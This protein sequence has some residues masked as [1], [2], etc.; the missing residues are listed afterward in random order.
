MPRYFQAPRRCSC[1]GHRAGRP[2]EKSDAEDLQGYREW[3]SEILTRPSTGNGPNASLGAIYLEVRVLAQVSFLRADF[4]ADQSDMKG[5]AIASVIVG[6]HEGKA[7][8][9]RGVVRRHPIAE[10]LQ[11][12]EMLWNGK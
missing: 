8:M 6:C 7:E 12:V 5:I 11:R 9:G 1:F 3:V 2:L 4:L 10:P